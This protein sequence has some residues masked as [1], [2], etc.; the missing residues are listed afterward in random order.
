MDHRNSIKNRIEKLRKNC[1]K[2]KENDAEETEIVKKT[3]VNLT[4]R[5]SVYDK[6][7]FI[8]SQLEKCT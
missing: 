7:K 8:E 6:I 2:N 5:N 3:K 4:G 1:D